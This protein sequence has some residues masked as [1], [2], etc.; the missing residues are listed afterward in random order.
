M[1]KILC[2]FLSALLLCGTVSV[3]ASAL[4][5]A[6]P[7]I[8]DLFAK[9]DLENLTDE[10]IAL[11]IEGLNFLKNLHLDVAS[12]LEAHADQ[13]PMALKAALH[14]AGLASFPLWERSAFWNFVF[15]WLLFGWIWM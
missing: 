10:Q 1:K 11:L 9:F 14:Q 7:T 15:K 2:V 5:P 4:M 6:M 12:Y 3:A 8:D 13:L